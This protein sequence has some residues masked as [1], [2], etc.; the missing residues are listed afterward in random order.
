MRIAFLTGC[1]ESGQDGVGDYCRILA[2]ALEHEGHKIALIAWNDRFVE[3]ITSRE[4]GLRMPRS[5]PE[6]IKQKTALAWIEKWKPDVLSLQWVAFAFHPRGLP[7]RFLRTLEMIRPLISKRHL[8]VHEIWTGADPDTPLKHRMLGIPQRMLIRRM[9]R[10]WSPHS[11]HTQV[12]F[13]QAKLKTALPQ[14]KLLPLF[15]N[16]RPTH[17][18]RAPQPTGRQTLKLIVFG[19]IPPECCDGAFFRKAASAAEAAKIGLSIRCIGRSGP[20]IDTFIH[21]AQDYTPTIRVEEFG[22]MNP[23]NISEHLMNADFGVALSKPLMLSKSGVAAAFDEHGLPIL[24]A[25]PGPLPPELGKS[26]FFRVPVIELD[27]I[28]SSILTACKA[29]PAMPKVD[30]VAQM[31]LKTLLCS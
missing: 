6:P 18:D 14:I 8:M 3:E 16:I 11:A 25:R 30:T 1:T 26:P 21:A 28:N 13:H 4:N 23:D 29:L 7:F 22:Q 12:P 31:L 17:L 15:G 2:N 5:T 19:T 20:S 9:I 10:L 24:C 27:A